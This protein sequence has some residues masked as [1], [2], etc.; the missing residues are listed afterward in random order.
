MP[1]LRTQLNRVPFSNAAR[2][3]GARA[4]RWK[5]ERE[6]VDGTVATLQ[7]SHKELVVYDWSAILSTMQLSFVG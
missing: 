5:R 3:R 4:R 6:L 7:L 1:L 2:V